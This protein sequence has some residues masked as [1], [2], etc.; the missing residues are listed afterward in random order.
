MRSIGDKAEMPSSYLQKQFL[1]LFPGSAMFLLSLKVEGAA[2]NFQP[3]EG[4][5]PSFALFNHIT[6]SQTQTRTTV[7][8]T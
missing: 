2:E 7:P 1:Y 4:S 8:S 6:F 5:S 3:A